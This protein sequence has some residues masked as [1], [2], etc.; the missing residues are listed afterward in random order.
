[1]LI[2]PLISTPYISRILGPE[3]IGCYSFYNSICSYF[4]LVAILGTT[5]F[6]QREISFYQDNVLERSKAFWENL[7]IRCITTVIVMVVWIIYISMQ[8]DQDKNLLEALSINILGV[9]FDIS[10]FFQGMEEFGK[11]VS[12]NAVFKILNVILIFIF[13]KSKDDLVIYVLLLVILNILAN[14]SLWLYLPNY[15][16]KIAIKDLYPFRNIKTIFSLFIPSIAIQIYTVLDKTMIGVFTESSYENGYYEQA[17]NMSK[18]ILS[19]VVAMVTVLAPRMGYYY[20]KKDEKKLKS[21]LYQSYRFVCFLAVPFCLGLF[22]VADN[23]IPW[24]F[25]LDYENMI[26]VLKV[27]SFLILVIGMNSVT[28]NQYLIPTKQHKGYTFSVLV[29]AFC[30][31]TLNLFL[32]P[33][34]YALGAVYTSVVAETLIMLIQFWFV[35]N[36][37]EIRKI[38]SFSKNYLIA[39]ICM[40]IVL[41][42]EDKYLEAMWFNTALL[43]L[44]GGLTYF[45]ILLLLKD[46]FFKDNINKVITQVKINIGRK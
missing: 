3:G 14:L 44:S 23:L 46:V 17:I 29:G 10:W 45:G 12:K 13:V 20:E 36:E 19:L 33:R 4:V 34:Y 39:G 22:G 5:S 31:F 32:I 43:I 42:L 37:I 8:P 11:T 38:F 6:G 15:I 2:V 26:P 7:I 24:F 30:N 41:F 9:V 27:S 25:G 35:R 28:G 40:L 16:S 1:M 18:M 21:Y